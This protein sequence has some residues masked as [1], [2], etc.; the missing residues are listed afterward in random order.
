MW[1]FFIPVICAVGGAYM[2]QNRTL[3]FFGPDPIGIFLGGVCGLIVGAILIVAAE[4]LF[5]SDDSTSSF[6]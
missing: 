6:R 2:T 1:R 3:T 4:N 5:F